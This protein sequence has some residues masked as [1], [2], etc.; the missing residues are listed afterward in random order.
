MLPNCEKHN[1]SCNVYCT[2]CDQIMC[3]SCF[4][5]EHKGHISKDEGIKKFTAIRKEYETTINQIKRLNKKIDEKK[6]DIIT[7]IDKFTE[8]KQL[9][10]NE[11]IK[12]EKK[13]ITNQLVGVV[14][15]E[16]YCSNLQ[17]LKNQLLELKTRISQNDQ[18]STE[19]FELKDKIKKEF[20]TIK[21]EVK[22]YTS[23]NLDKL[24]NIINLHSIIP[25]FIYYQLLFKVK[26]I[27]GK[28]KSQLIFRNNNYRWQVVLSKIERPS[29]KEEKEF[30]LLVF[31]SPV[32]RRMTIQC[33]AII[34][35]VTPDRENHQ[36]EGELTFDCEER[37]NKNFQNI[38]KTKTAL[39]L[40]ITAKELNDYFSS[41]G[42]N[43][44]SIVI[45]FYFKFDYYYSLFINNS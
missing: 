6:S 21:N 14:P 8:Q 32:L 28:V 17:H 18:N 39:N 38:R 30:E 4:L 42:E 11:F 33:K 12:K 45:D 40:D 35:S 5:D 26:D 22:A 20:E 1:K 16:M 3:D 9:E 2:K 25:P 24:L 31:L 10:L 15:T 23:N 44:Y 41:K 43:G 27:S 7:K 29:K 34:K 37:D 13:V 19:I 36:V